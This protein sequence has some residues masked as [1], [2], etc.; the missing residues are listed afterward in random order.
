MEHSPAYEANRSLA[1]G[2]A[3][4]TTDCHRKHDTVHTVVS[5][6][7]MLLCT[8][9]TIIRIIPCGQFT[10]IGLQASVSN[11]STISSTSAGTL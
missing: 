11:G 7:M 1:S 2:V 3:Y 6:R 9:L 10:V 5:Q 4:N 8:P